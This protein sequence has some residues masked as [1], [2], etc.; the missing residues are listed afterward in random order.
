MRLWGSLA[1]LVSIASSGY[2]SKGHYDVPATENVALVMGAGCA[3]DR[4][5]EAKQPAEK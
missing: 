4:V 5:L 2:Q 3:I 1:C